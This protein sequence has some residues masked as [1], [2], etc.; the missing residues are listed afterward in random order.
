MEGL[1]L[2]LVEI[3]WTS[4]FQIINIITILVIACAIGYF[5]YKLPWL[6]RLPKT[7][8]E[9]NEKIDRLERKID[10][11]EKGINKK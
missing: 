9:C 3:N 10:D 8:N 7:V 1:K 2:G 6:F 5:I 4:I 11:L